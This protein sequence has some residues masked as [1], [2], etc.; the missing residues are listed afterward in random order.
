MRSEKPNVTH[1]Q[2]PAGVRG[3][4]LMACNLLI[5]VLNLDTS[6]YKTTLPQLW[7]NGEIL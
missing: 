3:E 1:T 2:N 5:T 6:D 7:Y 4:P